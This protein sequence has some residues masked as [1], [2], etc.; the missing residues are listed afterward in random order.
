MSTTHGDDAT[1]AQRHRRRGAAGGLG[2]ETID[3]FAPATGELLSARR[4][5]ARARTS[6][7]RSRAAAAA[8]PAWA[9]ETPSPSAARILR[10]DRPAARARRRR[11]RRRSSPPR[12][13]SRPRTR[14]A[15]PARAIEMGYF[16]AGEGR[17]FYGRTTTSAVPNRQAMTVRQPLGVAGPDHR[18]QHADRQR[19]L[20]GL[21]G[22]RCAATPP[23]S[24]R[25]EDTPETALAF[26]RLAA[27]GGPA[28]RRAQRRPGP[29]APR[30]G[31]RSSRTR[32]VAVVSLH[33]L[34]RGRPHDRPR[35]RRAPGQG[36]PRA[37]RQEPAGRLRRRRPRGR[38]RRGRA[39]GV[40]QRRPALR[41]GQPD[42]RLRRRL[43]RVHARCCSSARGP[44]ASAPSDDDDFGPVINERQ[45]E[46]MLGAVERAKAA[47]RDAS[48]PAASALRP[49]AAYYM[50]PD[51]DRGRRPTRASPAP[52]CSG[53]SPTLHRVARLR[54]G[55]R[56]S[57]TTRRTG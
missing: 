48:W 12:P 32:D 46:N 26:A 1:V 6:T 54:R 11:G 4:P 53:R 29:R 31:S 5:L 34:D 16:V 42:H 45:L 27:R 15:R 57:P 19:R 41:G 20:E 39:V 17:R 7:P 10:R 55:A 35:G 14:S 30:P 33:R 24:R 56:G 40:L 22:A 36:L 49:A 38:R 8:Q 2:G 9:R 18:R 50:A 28:R 23:C 44:S 47:G 37:R 25:R 43:R 13:A 51:A 21:P 3:K 52:S